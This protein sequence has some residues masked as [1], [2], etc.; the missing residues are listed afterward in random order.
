MAK[1]G[2]ANFAVYNIVCNN[3]PA[4]RIKHYKT[5]ISELMGV[6][7]KTNRSRYANVLL[8]LNTYEENPLLQVDNGN[9][10][11][12]EEHIIGLLW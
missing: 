12:E 6:A 11:E 9:P 7:M 1:L 10:D 4:A 8:F 5:N 2:C 3:V